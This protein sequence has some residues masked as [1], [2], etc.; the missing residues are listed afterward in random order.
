MD[1]VLVVGNDG[2]ARVRAVPDLD[3]CGNSAKRGERELLLHVLRQHGGLGNVVL[4]V[5]VQ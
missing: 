2:G 3:G 4:Q 1:E 5:D